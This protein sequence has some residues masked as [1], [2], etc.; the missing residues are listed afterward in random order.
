M[1]DF[2]VSVVDS[3][4]PPAVVDVSGNAASFFALLAQLQALGSMGRLA[5]LVLARRAGSY[6][7]TDVVVTLLAYF[8]VRSRDGLREFLSDER[9]RGAAFAA[10]ANRLRWITQ[11]S[12]SRALAS[13]GATAAAALVAELLGS[14]WRAIAE[15]KVVRET[16]NRD[17]RG[18]P[19]LVVDWDPTILTLRKRALPESQA[20]PIGRRLS[21]AIAAAGYPGRKRGDVQMSRATLAERSTGA[22]L[23]CDLQPGN[24]KLALQLELAVS[25]LIA[26]TEGIIDRART[27]VVCDGAS[28]GIRQVKAWSE[29]GFGVLVR[30]SMYHV[31]KRAETQAALQT[32]TWCPVVDSLSGP[33]RM[34]AQVGIHR[35]AD[36]SEY[37]LM[38]SRYQAKES[39]VTRGAGVT[40]DGWRYELWLTNLPADAWAAEDCVQL[41][42]GRAAVENR[43]SREDVELD[44][45]RVF[46]FESAG[47]LACFAV[48]L[49]CWNLQILGGLS[50]VSSNVPTRRPK[51][52]PA[53]S[54]N[55]SATPGPLSQM[56]PQSAAAS[57]AP[58][59][60][61]VAARVEPSEGH[62]LEPGSPTSESVELGDESEPDAE[63]ESLPLDAME[64]QLAQADD[65][66][67]KTS[68]TNA[69][70]DLGQDVVVLNP[71]TSTAYAAHDDAPGLT[72]PSTST[73]AILITLDGS[74]AQ[75][76]DATKQ[77]PVSQPTDPTL[78]L[79]SAVEGW[80][81]NHLGWKSGREPLV[82]I[83]PAGRTLPLHGF[84]TSGDHTSARFR[85]KPNACTGCTVRKQCAPKGKPSTSRHEV[86]L[87]LSSNDSNAATMRRNNAT[88]H[89]ASNTASAPAASEQPAAPSRTLTLT[90]EPARP[91]L[92]PLPSMLLPAVLKKK[93]RAAGASLK[94][95]VTLP[96]PP[97]KSAESDAD[98][99]H[100]AADDADRQRRRLTIE[101]RFAANAQPTP[102]QTRI[103]ITADAK[104]AAWYQGLSGLRESGP[105]RERS[106]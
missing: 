31:L 18:E 98:S 83:C 84:R 16:G 14:T 8:A 47:Q 103:Q 33:R 52:R 97:E 76:A 56:L 54:L 72:A 63:D 21:D 32:A 99:K 41:Y 4:L 67:W 22:W 13:F 92:L 19:W 86:E 5:N 62:V 7:V 68:G 81:T 34:A 100:L 20:H 28:G 69:P 101:Q 95:Q 38:A 71:S 46:C 88:A 44:T 58:V 2:R 29:A 89:G 85:A 1:A 90:L 25:A 64:D 93:Y 91:N 77:S 36:G 102:E 9:A 43:F 82:L 104:T 70:I 39:G 48:G 61:A 105:D 12:L 55:P 50:L 42:F 40:I 51:A 11:S 79:S 15:S 26:R 49:A 23:H 10:G 66:A 73:E 60:V 74:T 3:E 87:R 94:I 106:A 75:L 78:G 96:P 45:E 53:S 30:S 80:L 37:R 57:S 59:D 24:G 17:C 6:E 35:E 65:F 27:V